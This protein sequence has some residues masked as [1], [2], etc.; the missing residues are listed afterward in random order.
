MEALPPGEDRDVVQGRVAGSAPALYTPISWGSI[1]R[2][3]IVALIKAA[4]FWCILFGLVTTIAIWFFVDL[5]VQA[6]YGMA[7]ILRGSYLAW[8]AINLLG[9][10]H[11][12]G[13]VRW[14]SWRQRTSFR[15]M[16]DAVLVAKIRSDTRYQPYFKKMTRNELESAIM[17]K[18]NMDLLGQALAGAM[19]GALSDLLGGHRRGRRGSSLFD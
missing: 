8:I 11:A 10:I 4:L 17:S 18:R 13:Y 3:N 12:F 6:H 7:E 2:P 14:R 9:L 1:V 5:L 16:Y 15:L 19:F